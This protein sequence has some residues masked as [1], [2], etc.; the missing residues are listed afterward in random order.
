MILRIIFLLQHFLTKHKTTSYKTIL[1]QELFYTHNLLSSFKA[2]KNFKGVQN[3]QNYNK[4]L[5]S[6]IIYLTFRSYN[7]K[8]KLLVTAL[9]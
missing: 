7:F 4:D 5:G 8:K 2:K 3:V 1:N 6:K 9:Y